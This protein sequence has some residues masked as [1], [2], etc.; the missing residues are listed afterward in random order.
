[1]INTWSQFSI[2]IKIWQTCIFI[3]KNANSR[4]FWIAGFRF[5]WRTR[6]RASEISQTCLRNFNKNWKLWARFWSCSRPIRS[7]DCIISI[8]ANKSITLWNTFSLWFI[9]LI[10][11]TL[12]TAIRSAKCENFK[13]V[14]VILIM[15]ETMWESRLYLYHCKMSN[16]YPLQQLFWWFGRM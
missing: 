16:P 13:T 3:I 10:I 7:P 1:M 9:F 8:T 12:F 6:N 15:S 11:Y 2:F 14:N 4:Y 5:L